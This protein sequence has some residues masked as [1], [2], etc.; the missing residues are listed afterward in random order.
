M[1]RPSDLEIIIELLGDIKVLLTD[2]K[3]CL[4]RPLEVVNPPLVNMDLPYKSEGIAREDFEKRMR[5]RNK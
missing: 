2:L 3:Y 1:S 5:D 4:R